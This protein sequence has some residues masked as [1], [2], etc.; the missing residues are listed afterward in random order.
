MKRITAIFSVL[1]MMMAMSATANAQTWDFTKTDAADVEALSAATSEWTYTE[2]SKRYEN[3]KAISGAVKAGDTELALTRGLSVTA[4]EKKLRI[5][6][7]NRLQLAGK[8]VQLTTPSLKKGQVVTI[9]F[10]STGTTA[11][12]L[13]AVSNLSGLTGFS[14]A[15]KNTTQTGTGTVTADGAV[16]FYSTVGSVNVF[17]LAVTGSG[18]GS[19]P[20]EETGGVE[21]KL[22]DV[23]HSVAS[24]AAKNQVV[25]AL[26]GSNRYYNTADVTSIDL[27]GGDISIAQ[28]ND[29]DTYTAAIKSLSF[30]KATVANADGKVVITEAQGWLESAYVKFEPFAGATTY[31]VYVKGGQ[32][33]DFTK[34]DGQLVRNY[35]TYGRADVVGLKAASDYVLRVVPV[36]ADGNELADNANEATALTV[37]NYSR[38]G[39]AFMGGYA[40]GAYNADGTLKAGAKVFYVTKNTAKTITTTVKTGSKDTNVSEVTGLQAIIDAY[41][42]GYDTTPIAFRFIGLIEKDNLDAISSSEE[43]LQIKGKNADSELNLTFE[44]IGDDATVRGF[45]FLVRNAKSV[46]FRNFAILRCM[47]DGISL[48]TDNSNIWLHHIDVFYGKSGSGDH[49]KGDGAIDVKSDSKFVTLSYCRF[50]DTGKSNMFGMKSESGPNYISYDHNWFDHSDSRHPRI[51]TMSVHVWNNYFDNC[52][53]YGVGATSGASVFVENNYFLKTK[54]PILASLQGTDAKGSGTFSGEDGGM[55][56]AYGNYFDRTIAH[57]SYYT[58]QNPDATT[59]YD[60]Y[61][62]ASRDAQVPST[63]VTKVGGTSYDNFDTNASLMYTYNAVSAEDVPALVTGYYGAGRLNH[64]DITYTF[65]DNV[66]DDNTDSAVDSQLSSL[67]DNYKSSLVGIFGDESAGSGEQG[68]SDNGGGDNGG[69]DNGGE[70]GGGETPTGTIV[71]TFDGQPSNSMFTVG[72]SYGDG[73]ITYEGTYYKKGV[74]LDSNG[75]ITFTPSQDYTMTLV[76]ATVKKGRDVKVNGTNTSGGTENT[77]GAYYTVTP[78]SITAGTEYV[79]TKGSGESMV[80]V[81]VLEPTA[82]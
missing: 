1:A 34:I 4:A 2:S 10:A 17:S 52:A 55:I 12:T 31:N 13:D 44:G 56:K 6:V 82:Q 39:F 21:A 74:K 37:K 3:V 20:G 9:V 16:T 45:G 69:G 23:D 68:G 33:A 61:E 79:L 43:G 50:W 48:D 58:Q 38:E 49:A 42:K 30:R 54:K 41:Q 63:E 53:K 81:I 72:G 62:T 11:V 5:D 27:A 19:E 67:I 57:F 47:D 7:D 75:S 32:Y 66:G 77:E 29:V 8:N 70:Q 14:A 18:E 25:V 15:D 71:A 65:T 24:T 36:D 51:R 73:K 46:E 35:G 80:M 78:V 28:G 59:G 22:P 60:A 26:A 64:G 40:P 76:L